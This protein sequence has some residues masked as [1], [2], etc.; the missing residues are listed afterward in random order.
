VIVRFSQW[1]GGHYDAQIADTP[2]ELGQLLTPLV[3]AGASAFHV[4]TR[5]YWLPGYD[6]S[7]RTFAGWT[8]KVSG[9]PVIAIGSVGV[10]EAFRDAGGA[11]A[12]LS[13]APLLDLFARGEFDLIAL[14]RA[15]LSD[16]A[17]PTKVRDG[18]LAE[19]RYYDKGDEARLT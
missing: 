19:I 1:K 15:L 6:N 2:T 10:A 18:R 7:R 16:P 14:G 4:S 3:D 5:R 13:L 11:R 17:W 12:P 8:K 9:L